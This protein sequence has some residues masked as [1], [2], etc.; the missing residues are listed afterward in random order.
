MW[1][2]ARTKKEHIYIS[3]LNAS[4]LEYLA[5]EDWRVRL[6]QMRVVF[7]L[8]DIVLIVEEQLVCLL[9]LRYWFTHSEQN[10]T[11]LLHLRLECRTTVHCRRRH[12]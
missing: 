4:V 12:P 6:Q 5:S 9:L 11:P 2:Q 7:D 10:L 1:D 8:H 3:T